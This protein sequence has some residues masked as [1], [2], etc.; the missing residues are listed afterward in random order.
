MD[1]VGVGDLKIPAVYKS[2]LEAP[3][4]LPVCRRTDAPRVKVW[5]SGTGA[6]RS[7]HKLTTV[8]VAHSHP[9]PITQTG[10]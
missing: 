1:L 3:Y 10:I 9:P 5:M 4:W 6:M 8:S 2:I 7:N